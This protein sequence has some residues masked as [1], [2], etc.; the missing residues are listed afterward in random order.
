MELKR[1]ERGFNLI[2][3]KDTYEKECWI[4]KSSIASYDAIWFGIC[5][6]EAKIL[7]S[8][9]KDYGI[10][11][12]ETCGWVDYP[13]PKDVLLTTTMHLSREQVKELIPILQKFVDTGDI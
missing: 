2:E 10:E 7:A 9:A 3:F 8:K 12:K 13:I 11:T 1:T 5:K 4:Q 6:N